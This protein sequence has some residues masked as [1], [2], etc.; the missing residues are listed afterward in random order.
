MQPAYGERGV[1]AGVAR[2]MRGAGVGP[3]RKS[4]W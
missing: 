1:Q 2:H 3:P 4:A